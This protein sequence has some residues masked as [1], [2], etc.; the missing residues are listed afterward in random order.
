MQ[1]F[2]F[3]FSYENPELF[4]GIPESM[5]NRIS[6]LVGETIR[7]YSPEPGNF[8]LN[9]TNDS[10]NQIFT[11]SISINCLQMVAIGTPNIVTVGGLETW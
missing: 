9:P 5:L 11:E 6:L 10:E 1:R 7:D 3:Y 2:C 4:D 8:Y